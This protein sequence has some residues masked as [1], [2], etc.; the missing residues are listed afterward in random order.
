MAPGEKVPVAAIV[1]AG[2]FN[3][4]DIFA[5]CRA[6]L[7]GSQIPRYLHVLS[8]IPKTASEK[9]IECLLLEAFDVKVLRR[10]EF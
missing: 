8:E 3:P 5:A 4:K 2:N 6:K 9:P 7:E 1:P 10:I